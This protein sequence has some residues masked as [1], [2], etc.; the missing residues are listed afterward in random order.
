MSELDV[1]KLVIAVWAY[2]VLGLF[3]MAAILLR[4]PAAAD[5]PVFVFSLLDWLAWPYAAW[6]KWR[7]RQKA[8]VAK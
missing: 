3:V 8:G 2:L 7:A 6:R 5:R 4:D 1:I